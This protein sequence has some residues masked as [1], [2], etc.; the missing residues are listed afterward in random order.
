MVPFMKLL[1]IILALSAIAVCLIYGLSGFVI[2]K[3]GEPPP[4][5]V[6]NTCH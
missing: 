1:A 6:S 3:I 5:E 4:C 2:G